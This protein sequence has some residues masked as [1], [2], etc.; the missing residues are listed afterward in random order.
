MVITIC[1]LYIT[2]HA[3]RSGVG[4]GRGLRALSRQGQRGTR[5]LPLPSTPG[6]RP[7]SAKWRNPAAVNRRRLPQA[8]S[9]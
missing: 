6:G 2:A 9:P 8:G 5:R 3:S 7:G 1:F 4:R